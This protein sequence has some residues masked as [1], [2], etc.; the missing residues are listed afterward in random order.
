MN[1]LVFIGIILVAEIIV[2]WMAYE[3]GFSN[4]WLEGTEGRGS[5]HREQ[6]PLS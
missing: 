2:L 3:L 5:T 1:T 6:R 4:G